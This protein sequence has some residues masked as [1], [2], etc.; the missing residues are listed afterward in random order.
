MWFQEKKKLL[1]IIKK[2]CPLDSDIHGLAHFQRVEKLGSYLYK[3]NGAD[4]KVIRYFAY[5][6]DC[7]R[8]QDGVDERHGA[9]AESF[10]QSLYAQGLLALSQQ[11]KE[12][13][14]YAVRNHHL[15]DASSEDITIQT[16]W[17]ADR[18]DLW[19]IDC[20]PNPAR[21]FTDIAKKQA[22]I[23]FARRLYLENTVQFCNLLLKIDKRI[24]PSLYK[25]GKR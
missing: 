9:R 15:E 6:H 10:V 12:L 8:I 1:K 13:L 14:C 24:N 20:R 7:M 11:Q 23:D 17:D 16:C 4:L 3:R 2:E 22:T 25:K 5:L 18:L 19:R 21:L